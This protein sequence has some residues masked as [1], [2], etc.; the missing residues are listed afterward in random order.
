MREA[1]GADFAVA[2]SLPG[3]NKWKKWIPKGPITINEVAVTSALPEFIM[4]CEMTAVEFG[5]EAK[6]E[7]SVKRKSVFAFTKKSTLTR[8]G[9]RVDIRFAVKLYGDG[10]GWSKEDWTWTIKRVQ[11]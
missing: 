1:T 4:T 10:L 8:K 9:D 2:G 11:K 3:L 6:Q 5:P 7:F